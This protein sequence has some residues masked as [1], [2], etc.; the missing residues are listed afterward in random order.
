MGEPMK[1][2]R[3][4]IIWEVEDGYV[5][6]SRPHT[7]FFDKEEWDEMSDDERHQCVHERAMQEI[8]ISWREA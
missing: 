7:M 2:D 6:G 1:Q 5:G 4:K 3:V 8:S